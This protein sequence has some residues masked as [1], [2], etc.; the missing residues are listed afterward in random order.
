LSSLS[1]L[2]QI[3]IATYARVAAARELVSLE[4]LREAVLAKSLFGCM[5]GE[6]A[7]D[8]KLSFADALAKPGLAF[9]C[10]L[11]QASP[12]KGKI[13]ES[14][15]YLSIA[16][17]Y[18]KAGA[19]AISVLTEPDFFM[20]S[21]EHLSEVSAG[22]ALPTLR[23]DFIIDEYQIYQAKLLGASAVLL[24][25]ALLSDQQLSDYLACIGKL[26]LDALVEVHSEA[27]LLRALIAGAKIIGVNNR[28]LKTFELD[29]SV[30]V[31]LR[32][33]IPDDCLF[34]VES[35]INTRTD[36]EIVELIDAD[37]VLVGETLMRAE[38]KQAKLAELKGL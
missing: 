6:G 38:D 37:A 10:E 12:S 5:S 19:D 3:T 33:Y 27:E 29:L 18:Q 21:D 20:G 4:Q 1:F 2:E 30:S 11:K 22:V 15:D 8:T 34:V 35:G 9:I 25:V 26:D 31:R 36:I 32:E 14:Y 28:D 24:I 13:A 17:V 16:R 7:A 23:K